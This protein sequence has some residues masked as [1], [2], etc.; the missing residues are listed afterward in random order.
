MK[1]QWSSFIMPGK[2]VKVKYD[3]QLSS[4][5]VVYLKDHPLL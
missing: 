4:V 2:E 3:S 1:L 5:V